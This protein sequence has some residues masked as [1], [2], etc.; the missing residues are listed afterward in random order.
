MTDQ[1]IEIRG[2][3]QAIDA[4]WLTQVMQQAGVAGDA[5][6]ESIE[7]VGL[8][9]TGQMGRN[10]RYNL[11]W[12]DPEGRPLSVVAKMASDD[13][14]A[15]NT[16]FLNGSYQT[17]WAF[18]KR[19]A[20]QMNV[21]VPHCYAALFDQAKPDFVLVMEDLANSRQGD[22]LVGL[23]ADECA[24]ALGEAV[25][26]HAPRW[27]DPTLAEFAPHKP[28]SNNDIL[29]P[30]Y[31]WAMGEFKNRLGSR[32]DDDILTLIEQLAPVLVDW[33]EASKIPQT[34]MHMDF[35]ADNL[36][37]G[38]GPDAPPVVVI[39][40][41]TAAVGSAL[42]DVAYLLGAGLA[43]TDRASLERDLL[44][45]YLAKMKAAGVEMD[46]DT[47]WREYR[48]GALWGLVMSVVATPGAEET[49]RGNAMLTQMAQS[50]GRHALELESLKVFC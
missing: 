47:A 2:E 10:A 7:F 13:E 48:L 43:P 45:D 4:P 42:W 50:H 6:I 41:Q 34:L 31:E 35:R 49:E 12:N 28:T 5:S 38:V 9:G 33:I 39:D 30:L 20:A 3:P 46:F 22:Q 8:I 23:T 40:W 11:N 19:L 15:R 32:V 24:L 18:Y 36:M 29:V 27:G 21:R 26:F 17:E 44:Q 37:F 14:T 16:G 25:G 1:P